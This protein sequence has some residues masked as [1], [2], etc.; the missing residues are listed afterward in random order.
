MHPFLSKLCAAAMLLSLIPLVASAAETRL[1]PSVP[2]LVRLAAPAARQPIQLQKVAVQTEVVGSFS[3]T[4]VEMV[5][6]NPN[7]SQL[8]GELQFPLLDGQA[9]TGFALDIN[10]EMRAAVPVDK[11]RG[12]QVF[13]EVSRARIDPALLEQTQGNNYRLRVYPLPAHGTRRVALEI[14]GGLEAVT[15]RGARHAIFR[16]PL[17]FAGRVGMLDVVVN[18]V[19]M[20]DRKSAMAIRA[21]LGAE[22]IRASHP[23]RTRP[24]ASA[25]SRVSLSRSNYA[26]NG[27]LV[28]DYP[29][30]GKSLTTTETR[31]DQTYFYA[32]VPVP[33]DRPVMR[34][35]PKKIGLVWDASGSGALR[36][37]GREFALLDACFKRFGN[38]KVELTIARDR[39]ED[40]RTFNIKQG[41]W[42]GLRDVLEALAYDGATAAE[43]LSPPQN[44]DLNLLFSDG[45][46]NYG[47]GKLQAG[48][49]PLFA[50]NVAVS[51]DLNRLRALAEPTGG[52]LLDMLSRPL[53]EAVGELMSSSAHLLGLHSD[54]AIELV[55]ASPYPEAGVLK[56]AGL[57]TQPE[58]VL[59]L[60]WQDAQGRRQT[61]QVMLRNTDA[62]GGQ[63]AARRWATLMLARLDAD[64]TSNRAT[65]RRLGARFGMV[66]RET[67]LIV[68]DSIQDYVRYEIE[69]PASLR[70]DYER[71]L[72]DKAR[73]SRAERAAHLDDIAA[74]FASKVAWW[75][76]SF[77][78]GD[79]PAPKQE[80]VP[81]RRAVGMAGTGRPAPLMAAAPAPMAEAAPVPAAARASAP[82]V[83][84]PLSADSPSDREPPQVGIQLK[85][86]QPDAP[87][88]RRLNEAPVEQMY[89]VYLDERPSWLDSTAFFLDVADIFIARGQPELGLRILS[90][91]AEMN[92]ENR[93]ILRILAYRLTQAGQV[94]LALPVLQKVLALSPDEP[95][96]WRDL[97]LAYT[98]DG[99]YQQ[100]VNQLWEVVAHP[101]HGRFPDIELVALAELN[102]IVARAPQG[103]LDTHRMD[104]RLLRNLPLDL[105]VVLSWDA[106]NT[107]IDLWVTDP[108]GEKVYF[109]NRL[110]YQGGAISQDFTGGYGPEE[111]SLRDAKPGIYKVEAHFYGNRQQI[112]AGA[113]TLMLRLSTGFGTAQQKDENIILR[114]QGQGEIV[115]VGTFEVG[116]PR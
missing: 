39:A 67:S 12:Q 38:V 44:T 13:E 73:D 31:G 74:R 24:Q 75:E 94:R 52:R 98:E 2:T 83:T 1:P 110:G 51:A 18:N 15:I 21:H 99:Q 3:H 95:Q 58:A 59:S 17:Q 35:T 77:P 85:R 71:L 20:S 97:G 25:G 60:D 34:P 9:V 72:A 79:K 87:Y 11:A 102:A 107:D 78:K 56:V 69:P 42:Q 45:M 63:L 82:A 43:A 81:P 89:R 62:A 54:G 46:V 23:N 57:L 64:Y 19:T 86:W 29:D 49:A 115:D 47:A 92:L 112:V 16:L 26:G 66:T 108:N 33:A 61:Q 104:A 111:F 55:G 68:L 53:D 40:M 114:L 41:N 4:R 88:A 100:A 103:T 22:T 5:F 65:I 14:E 90:N 36:D 116:K 84:A 93:Q 27:V 30:A 28:I 109:A 8:E 101:W 106:D 91:L 105:R 113:T 37:H 70:A 10:G 48:G 50:V 7:A 96:S 32:E 76:K 80:E 6:Y